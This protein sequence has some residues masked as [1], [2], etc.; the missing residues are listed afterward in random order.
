VKGLAQVSNPKAQL[1]GG[2]ANRHGG[3]EPDPLRAGED[4]RESERPSGGQYAVKSGLIGLRPHGS[5]TDAAA[6][7][8]REHAHHVEDHRGQEQP[9]RTPGEPGEMASGRIRWVV[10]VHRLHGEILV[11]PGED[12]LRIAGRPVRSAGR[13]PRHRSS[14][15]KTRRPGAA[16]AGPG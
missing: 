2:Q 14:R 11:W 8:R 3:P 7:I 6:V 10:A 16:E 12:N 4:E 9:G 1:G 15:A 5:L 13:H